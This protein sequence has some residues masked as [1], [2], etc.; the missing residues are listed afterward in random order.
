MATIT[1]NIAAPS[2]SIFASL[3]DTL[4]QI[5]ARSPQAQKI[6]RLN[7]MNDAQLQSFGLRREDIARHVLGGSY[8]L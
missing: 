2:P 3:F 8:Y 6:D 4:V 5:G 7:N 1:T